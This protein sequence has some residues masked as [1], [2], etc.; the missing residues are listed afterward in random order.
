MNLTNGHGI[1]E[2]LNKTDVP[3]DLIQN[4]LHSD[5]LGTDE[6]TKMELIARHFRQIMI[7]LGLDLDDDSLKGTPDRVAKMYVK[8]IFSGLPEENKPA[9]SLFENK[10][11]YSNMLVEKNI[12]V[13]S[14]CEHHFLPIIGKAHVAYFPTKKIIGLSKINRI[15]HYYSRRPT[16]QE[17]LTEQIALEMKTALNT[18]DVAVYIDADHLCVSSRGI[19]DVNSSTITSHYSGKF[20]DHEVRHE[21][22]LLIK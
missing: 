22:L 8:E 19:Q 16:V 10:D 15:V 3:T 9:I 4:F 5:K 18:Q 21:F 12:T 6:K 2:I 17:K 20:L 13:Y 14:F 1:K 7:L 11:G